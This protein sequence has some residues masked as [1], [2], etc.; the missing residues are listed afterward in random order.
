MNLFADG[1][2]L[3]QSAT[4]F[5]ERSAKRLSLL[6]GTFAHATKGTTIG[7]ADKTADGKITLHEIDRLEFEA[8]WELTLRLSD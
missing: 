1:D 6:G 7:Q 2:A 4:D 8:A 3:G 5:P